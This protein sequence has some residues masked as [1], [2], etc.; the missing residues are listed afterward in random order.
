[1]PVAVRIL[2]VIYGYVV[3]DWAFESLPGDCNVKNDQLA[4]VLPT[5]WRS[6]RT[7]FWLL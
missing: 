1:V 6:S 5:R 2:D 7:C 3:I 4:A